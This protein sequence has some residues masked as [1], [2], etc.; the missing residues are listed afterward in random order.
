ME[1]QT[2]KELVTAV[3]DLTKA[4]KVLTEIG[5]GIGELAKQIQTLAKS[6]GQAAG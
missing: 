5:W 1:E 6:P 4:I 2:A 3:Q